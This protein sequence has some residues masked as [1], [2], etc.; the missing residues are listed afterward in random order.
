[1]ERR[2]GRRFGDG[3]SGGARAGFGAVG[4][5][6][7]SAGEERG[8][9]APFGAETGGDTESENGCSRRANESVE[10]IPD[11]VE[12]RNFVGEKF[13]DVESDGEAENDRMGEDV[14]FFGEMNN[15]EAFEKAQRGDGGVKIESGGEAGTEGEGDG[16][17]RIHGGL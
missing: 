16:L 1:G 17:E 8:G 9:P 15:V 4:S 11:R 6:G 2:V 12:V 3:V 7:D 13:E 14:K 10:K 5:E